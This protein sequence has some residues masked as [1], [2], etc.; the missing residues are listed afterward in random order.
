MPELGPFKLVVTSDEND[1]IPEGK[2][3]LA[4]YK[5]RP[6]GCEI[7]DDVAVFTYELVPGDAV[8]I[9][10]IRADDQDD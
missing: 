10:N 9:D 1:A 8:L 6:I 2:A 5:I 3:V 4:Y 7:K